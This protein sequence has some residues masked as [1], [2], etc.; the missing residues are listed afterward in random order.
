ML[1]KI[2]PMIFHQ[3][4]LIITLTIST[5]KTSTVIIKVKKKIL[6]DS[7]EDARLKL[8]VRNCSRKMC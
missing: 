3:N 6:E 8:F 7:F 2:K 5:L 4:Q 1:R